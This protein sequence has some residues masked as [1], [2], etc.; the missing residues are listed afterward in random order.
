MFILERLPYEI[1]VEI[2]SYLPQ[3]DLANV[4]SLSRHIHVL[5]EPLLYKAPI[6]TDCEGDTPTTIETLLRTILS[7][8][9]ERLAA[10]VHSLHVTCAFDPMR[11]HY[12]FE[13]DDENVDPEC[14]REQGSDW[15]IR[16][17]AAAALGIHDF[18]DT[19]E[20]HV[21]ILLHHLRRLNALNIVAEDLSDDIHNDHNLDWLMDNLPCSIPLRS[22]RSSKGALN[23][24]TLLTLLSH[25]SMRKID[26]GLLDNR[27]INFDTLG[28]APATSLVT[29]LRFSYINVSQECLE[30]IL[31]IPTALTYF[32]FLSDRDHNTLDL[33]HALQ[34]LRRSLTHLHLEYT[35]ATK[36]TGSFRDWPLLCTV[37]CSLTALFGKDFK[38]DTLRLYDAL[39]VRLRELEIHRT[40]YW[41][42]A[43]EVNQEVDLLKHKESDVPELET[44]VVAISPASMQR[45][46]RNQARLR[47]AC[48][49]A[50]VKLSEAVPDRDRTRQSAGRITCRAQYRREM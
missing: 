38:N 32:S 12:I 31:K 46:V 48:H 25:P 23:L 6:I 35:P 15:A 20:E 13:D 49:D 28:V 26:C 42:V 1:S 7:P 24:D 16:A 41:S 40:K 14:A 11:Y 36:P 29:D 44:L 45:D 2:L 5:S 47:T 19:P 33:S 27:T 3:S 22:F 43:A 17:A 10:L 8:G 21:Q 34:P 30:F 37:R 9:G 4:S 50:G 39:P 18:H